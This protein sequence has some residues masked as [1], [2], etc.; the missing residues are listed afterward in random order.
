MTRKPMHITLITIFA[1]GAIS[2][3][4]C[5]TWKGLGKDVS[6][7]GDDIQGDKDSDAKSEESEGEG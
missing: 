3:T 4:G 5:E 2:L 1:L 6:S 7:L